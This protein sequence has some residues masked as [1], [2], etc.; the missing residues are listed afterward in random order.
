M[1]KSMFLLSILGLFSLLPAAEQSVNFRGNWVLDAQ[2]SDAQARE[3]NVYSS[4]VIVQTLNEI[5]LHITINGRRAYESF[6]LDGKDNVNRLPNGH[7]VTTKAKLKGNTFEITTENKYSGRKTK[8][9]RKY[10][11]SKDGKTLNVSNAGMKLVYNKADEAPGTAS[12]PSNPGPPARVVKPESHAAGAVESAKKQTDATTVNG[13]QL[14]NPGPTANVLPLESYAALALEWVKNQRSVDG[15]QLEIVGKPA[16]KPDAFRWKIAPDAIV[17]VNLNSGAMVQ[18]QALVMFSNNRPAGTLFSHRKASFSEG[19][20]DRTELQQVEK[21][22]ISFFAAA[23]DVSRGSERF[24]PYLPDDI[25]SMLKHPDRKFRL[26]MPPGAVD[27]S[28][29]EKLAQNR[30]STHPLDGLNGWNEKLSDDEL[31]HFVALQLDAV[32]QESVLLFRGFEK[33]AIAQANRWSSQELVSNPRELIK[34]IEKSVVQNKSL[35]EEAGIL[36]PEHLRVAS[37]YMKL[38]VSQGFVIKEVPTPDPCPC[39]LSSPAAATLYVTSFT[40]L[41]LHFT[42]MGGTLRIVCAALP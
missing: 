11:L 6:R 16:L 10:S 39:F 33:E 35:L 23:M 27:P 25:R 32:V 19:K 1:K 2:R 13:S 4:L 28:W 17:L 20:L 12:Q 3:S 14:T 42:R 34:S 40:S 41:T 22:L 15:L 31:R 8:V 30:V 29:R 18:D 5:Q 26:Y 37:S 7:E 21:E 38:M 9:T 24:Y 36:S